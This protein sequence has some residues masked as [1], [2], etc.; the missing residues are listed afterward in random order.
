MLRGQSVS[1][2]PIEAAE[3]EEES[4]SQMKSGSAKE[5]EQEADNED[6]E[7]KTEPDNVDLGGER[8]AYK[9]KLQEKE[10][11]KKEDEGLCGSRMVK[12]MEDF[13]F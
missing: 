13:T 6:E 12:K 5:S 9:K 2:K 8:D 10:I 11:E 4:A 1:M 3:S 7:Q